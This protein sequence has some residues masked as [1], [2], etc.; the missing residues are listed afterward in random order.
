MMSILKRET[1]A[2]ENIVK[3][4]KRFLPHQSDLKSQWEVNYKEAAI[5]LEE[6]L[7][8][9]KFTHHPRCQ[10]ALPAYLLVHNNW[11]HVFDVSAALVLLTLG[12]FEAPCTDSLCIPEQVQDKQFASFYYRSI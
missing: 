11:F 10:E 6:G 9:D 1:I 2:F 5:F 4:S 8:N 7:N 12:F 3:E